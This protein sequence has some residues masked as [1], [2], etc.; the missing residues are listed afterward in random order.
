MALWLARTWNWSM[1]QNYLII[2]GS[3]H[4]S[5]RRMTVPA[6]TTVLRSKFGGL[7]PLCTV[8][9]TV[10]WNSRVHVD[11][12]AYLARHG[13]VYIVL[14][15]TSLDILT[16]S[17]REMPVGLNDA[18]QI[19]PLLLFDRTYLGGCPSIP[20]SVFRSTW[21]GIPRKVSERPTYSAAA[22]ATLVG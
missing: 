7:L 8:P 9:L 4:C 16:R 19:P 14:K 17:I 12:R 13:L 15:W 1:L 6:T 11:K 3:F 21:N 2:K 22:V 20:S 10:S 18:A 5:Y